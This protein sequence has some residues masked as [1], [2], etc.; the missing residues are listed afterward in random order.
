MVL[1]L[2]AGRNTT[3]RVVF[4]LKL[5]HIVYSIHIIIELQ[6]YDDIIYITL[7]NTYYYVFMIE[8]KAMYYSVC[9]T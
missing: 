9:T 8:S 5:K 7:H 2:G 1:P 4:F 3:G 6:L